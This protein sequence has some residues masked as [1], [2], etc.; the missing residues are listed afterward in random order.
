MVKTTAQMEIPAMCCASC[1]GALRGYTE[2]GVILLP[3]CGGK[4]DH[5][6]TY[7]PAG[8]SASPREDLQ[9]LHRPIITVLSGYLWFDI[10]RAYFYLEAMR[11][12]RRPLFKRK[13]AYKER[14]FRKHCIHLRSKTRIATYSAH[15][16]SIIPH[17]IPHF[18]HPP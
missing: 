16:L 18:S 8:V 17:F 10:A 13:R 15:H 6:Q 9:A 14:R 3:V 2:V 4:Y 1:Y 5:S 12:V 11:E 7:L